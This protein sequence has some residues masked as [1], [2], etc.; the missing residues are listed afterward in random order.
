MADLTRRA[1]CG[2]LRVP[3][4]LSMDLAFTIS[5][6]LATFPA[7]SVYCVQVL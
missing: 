6:A 2:V 5:A 7:T 4:W 3:D 1:E